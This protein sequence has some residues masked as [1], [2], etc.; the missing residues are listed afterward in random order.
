MLHRRSHQSRRGPAGGCSLRRLR[1]TVPARVLA[2][3][4]RAGKPG[5]SSGIG[6]CRIRQRES[7]AWAPTRDGVSGKGGAGYRREASST[8]NPRTRDPYPAAPADR[9]SRRR[10]T[11]RGAQGSFICWTRSVKRHQS[12]SG[13]ATLT[14]MSRRH[15][16]NDRC[17]YALVQLGAVPKAVSLNELPVLTEFATAGDVR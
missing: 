12:I 14:G 1:A 17:E 3:C 4:V 2:R 7:E 6:P 11:G 10:S 8:W 16:R 5:T 9:G 13:C 15:I